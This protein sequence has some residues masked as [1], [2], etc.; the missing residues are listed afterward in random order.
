VI[1]EAL[2]FSNQGAFVCCRML[3]PTVGAAAPGH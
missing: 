2:W 1:P 3:I